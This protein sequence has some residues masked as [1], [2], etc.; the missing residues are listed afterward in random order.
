MP[1]LVDE[2]GT[3][4]G[5]PS[6]EQ[7]AQQV[8]AMTE[9]E[10]AQVRLIYAPDWPFKATSIE[11]IRKRTGTRAMTPEESEEFWR[12]HGPLMQPADGEG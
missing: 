12:G 10:A 11:E 7:V 4:T 9:A 5:L 6:A 8:K 2:S 3:P 1:R